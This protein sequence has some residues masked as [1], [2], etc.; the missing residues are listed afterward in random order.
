MNKSTLNQ[1]AEIN[2]QTSLKAIDNSKNITSNKVGYEYF[3]D[4]FIKN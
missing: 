1:A 3:N 4:L 2:K